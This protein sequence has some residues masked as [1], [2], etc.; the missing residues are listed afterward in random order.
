MPYNRESNYKLELIDLSDDTSVA[1]AGEITQTMTPPVGYIYEVKNIYVNCPP[2]AGGGAGTHYI[3]IAQAGWGTYSG[4]C[5]NAF[6]SAVLISDPAGFVGSS[7]VPSDIE[8]QYIVMHDMLIANSDN[9]IT[10]RYKNSTDVAA[11]LN[12]VIFVLVKVYR[13]AV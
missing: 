10:F 3:E 6:G 1:A 4:K 5:I 2:P 11:A 13:E 7:E 12:R 9:A 8:E